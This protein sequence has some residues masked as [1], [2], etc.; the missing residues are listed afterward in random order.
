[1]LTFSKEIN[2]LFES[3]MYWN[4]TH[5]FGYEFIVQESLSQH[6]VNFIHL[7]QKLA[8]NVFWGWSEGLSNTRS[9][10]PFP[11]ML[12]GLCPININFQ[13]NPCL[14]S[15]LFLVSLI[16]K[17]IEMSSKASVC[18]LKIPFQFSLIF[19]FSVLLIHFHWLNPVC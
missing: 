1:M 13:G 15:S 9:K 12:M 14:S 4:K 16:H 6:L 10:G 8:K 5:C 19:I 2:F 7:P 18:T 3:F 17:V 11:F